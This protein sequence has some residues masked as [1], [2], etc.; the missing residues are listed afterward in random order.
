MGR[1]YDS[2]STLCIRASSWPHPRRVD[3]A[4]AVV[5]SVAEHSSDGRNA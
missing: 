2:T 4:H 3:S 1:A 5:G